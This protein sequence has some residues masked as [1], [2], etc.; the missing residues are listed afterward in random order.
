MF[1]SSRMFRVL[2]NLFLRHL[3][4]H[5]CLRCIMYI[6]ET[7][8]RVRILIQMWISILSA[9][10]CQALYIFFR[11]W[12]DLVYKEISLSLHIKDKNWIAFY[13]VLITYLLVLLQVLSISAVPS[14]LSTV[15]IVR[16]R[17]M[18]LSVS[19]L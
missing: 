4:I 12:T 7:S 17:C 16:P 6:L 9:V 11:F 13:L 2:S 10:R 18:L 15:N 1:E 3:S 8:C 5:K 19:R 14:T